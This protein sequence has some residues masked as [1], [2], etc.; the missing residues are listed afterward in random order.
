[1]PSNARHQL[2]AG[3][4]ELE[5]LEAMIQLKTKGKKGPTPGIASG[6]R[7]AVVLLNAHFEAFLADLLQEA[8]SY[9][10]PGLDASSLRRAFTTPRP[11]NIDK[12][13]KILGIKKLSHEPSWQKAG[14]KVVR[15][16]IDALQTTR[17]AIAHGD[18]NAKAQKADITR[19]EGY[20]KGFAD[21]ADRIVADRVK[22]LTGKKPW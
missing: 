17:N 7:A 5:D 3:L 13:F 14:N 22:A 10:N 12:F 1:M 8:L 16:N 20:V 6:R 4:K 2:D 19:F 15:K 18:P 11:K 9:L 21:A